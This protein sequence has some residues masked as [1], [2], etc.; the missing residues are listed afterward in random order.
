MDFE[1]FQAC[2]AAYGAERRR[3]PL[4]DQPL[5]DHFAA[6]PEGQAVLAAAARD[7]GFL[8]A[9][10][11]AAPGVSIARRIT[12]RTRPAWRRLGWPAATLAASAVLGFVLGFAQVREAAG[13][14]I[15]THLLLGPGNLQEVAL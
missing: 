1:R 15:P 2:S 13:S 5:H 7:D 9:F 11:P 8:D 12:G 6:M 10:E 3:W 4:R 14:D